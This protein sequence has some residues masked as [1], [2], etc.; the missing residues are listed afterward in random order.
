MDLRQHDGDVPDRELIYATNQF[1]MT[2]ETELEGV[3]SISTLQ[4]L[5]S[6]SHSAIHCETRHCLKRIQFSM[7]QILKIRYF[8][9]SVTYPTWS[10]LRFAE[11]RQW[12]GCRCHWLRESALYF[13]IL[14]MRNASHQLLD[15]ITWCSVLITWCI[16]LKIRM[17]NHI[18]DFIAAP[19]ASLIFVYPS[20][21]NRCS[22]SVFN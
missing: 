15:L 9:Q 5:I 21:C 18:L 4:V 16:I 14:S 12:I 6:W 8:H 1:I 10:K 3:S 19:T 11:S 17:Q 2:G 22:R 7:K 13:N 20:R